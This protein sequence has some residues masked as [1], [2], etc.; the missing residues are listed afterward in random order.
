MLTMKHPQETLGMSVPVGR[1]I[2]A[3]SRVSWFA[4]LAAVMM[5]IGGVYL[6]QINSAATKTFVLRERE[7]QLEHLRE[8]VSVLE[9]QSAKW[10]AIKFLEE[11]IKSAGFV[12]VEQVEYLNPNKGN[13]A[14]AK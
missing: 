14:R 12:A 6:Y 9:A 5:A 2:S 10:Q 4:L 3:A 7:K 11:R 8:N 13:V 1:R